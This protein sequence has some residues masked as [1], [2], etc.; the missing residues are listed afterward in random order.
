MALLVTTDLAYREIR[1][2]GSELDIVLAGSWCLPH[3][4]GAH[5]RPPVVQYHW[6]DREKF[7]RDFE[8]LKV[9]HDYYLEALVRAL[10]KYHGLE[11]S[12]DYWRLLLGAWLGYSIQIVYDRYQTLLVARREHKFDGI[13]CFTDNKSL[14]HRF[15]NSFCT[16]FSSCNW[17]DAVFS[18]IA[19]I[20]GMKQVFIDCSNACMDSGM[21]KPRKKNTALTMLKRL[22]LKSISH[23]HNP[24]YI[25]YQS[26]LGKYDELKASLFLGEIPFAFNLGL[27][28]V[29]V[30]W[31][32][33]Y[34][35]FVR[36]QLAAELSVGQNPT[37]GFDSVLISFL[38]K[39]IP[40]IFVEEY[41]QFTLSISRS[42][43]PRKPR[44]VMTSNAIFFNDF[45]S[46][47][48]ADV[49]RRGYGKLSIG[50]HGG[51]FGQLKYSFQ[52]D[53]Q[54]SICDEFLSWG[55]TKNA[56][57]LITPFYM[58]NRNSR[59]KN[60]KMGHIV[61]ILTSMPRLSYS[62]LSIPSG[63]KQIYTMYDLVIEFLN[64]LNTS[65][66]AGLVIRLPP[67]DYGLRIKDYFKRHL[68][69]LPS[70]SENEQSLKSL[71][72]QS[73]LT[74]C[75]YGHATSGLETLSQDLATILLWDPSLFEFNKTAQDHL[76]RL[77]DASIFFS[78][79]IDAANHVNHSSLDSYQSWWTRQ[80]VINARKQF[81]DTY[82]RRNTYMGTQ[83]AQKLR[84]ST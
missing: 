61:V 5:P 68:T 41:E 18:L 66:L 34:S 21:A 13:V 43:L 63:A 2:L 76:K 73:S 48:L 78:S 55:W 36:S 81:C 39:S 3:G 52:E 57:T 54:L 24:E 28:T 58:L 60:T 37:E 29:E 84:E 33:K 25:V 22:T 70:F 19:E 32:F 38:S 31:D 16:S 50:Q 56:Q 10:N 1:K 26:Y 62:M 8:T 6:D 77:E 64:G 4:S 17:N 59:L 15:S 44:R 47:W 9:C 74:V 65:L 71:I 20:T 35:E 49:Q 83:L 14:R 30:D 27:K 72:A 7:S 53:Y 45:F 80:E 42:N 23:L 79:G 75:T 69:F 11:A 82:C 46:F 40:S 51:G 12:T 67:H